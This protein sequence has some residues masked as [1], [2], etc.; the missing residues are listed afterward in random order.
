MTSLWL[1]VRPARRAGR[2]PS[3]KATR[4]QPNQASARQ[5]LKPPRF[6]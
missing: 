5:S 6:G 1:R 2:E 3:G 4:G